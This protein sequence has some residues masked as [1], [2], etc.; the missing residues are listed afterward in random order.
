[1]SKIVCRKAGLYSFQLDE[2]IKVYNKGNKE[3]NS[4]KGSIRVVFEICDKLLTNDKAFD[5]FLEIFTLIYCTLNNRKQ[6]FKFFVD[7]TC[8]IDKIDI[9]EKKVRNLE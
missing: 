3:K 5:N 9:A 4:K 2:F 1:F 7:E 8:I 6:Q